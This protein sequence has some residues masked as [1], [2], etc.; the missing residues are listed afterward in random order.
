MVCEWNVARLAHLLGLFLELVK[1]FGPRFWR[2]RRY[3]KDGD[4]SWFMILD[5]DSSWFL[6]FFDGWWL[7]IIILDMIVAIL[8]QADM[9]SILHVFWR[10]ACW[11]ARD[12]GRGTQLWFFDGWWFWMLFDDGWSCLVI[13]DDG[14]WFQSFANA[15]LAGE[16]CPTRHSKWPIKVLFLAEPTVTSRLSCHL[17]SL[18]SSLGPI[19]SCDNVTL[20]LRAPKTLALILS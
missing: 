9:T 13:F 19:S 1:L 12:V 15:G 14:W 4:S 10:I 6:M 5:G 20:T 3:D 7:S 11:A 17:S 18:R 2:M 16:T 8:Q